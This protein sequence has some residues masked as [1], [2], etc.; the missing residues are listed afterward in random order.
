M[1]EL[2]IEKNYQ[3]PLR[4]IRLMLETNLL[5]PLRSVCF[6]SEC[7][8]RMQGGMNHQFIDLEIGGKVPQSL[9]KSPSLKL[10]I[11]YFS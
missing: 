4:A 6:H 5:T 8:R 2:S 10:F 1:G 11:F 7:H 3:L 9:G